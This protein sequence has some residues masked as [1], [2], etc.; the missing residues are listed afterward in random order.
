MAVLGASVINGSLVINGDTRIGTGGLY[1]KDA[2][3]PEQTSP[4][5][6]LVLDA[7]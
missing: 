2:S 3:L 5:Y 7:G 1:W 6:F 4:Q